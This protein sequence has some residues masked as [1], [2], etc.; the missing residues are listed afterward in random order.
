MSIHNK[1]DATDKQIW[2][3]MWHEKQD[4]KGIPKHFG[5]MSIRTM[6]KPVFKEVSECHIRF[7]K[8]D[9]HTFYRGHTFDI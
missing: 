8:V 9:E 6:I 1:N 4:N 7:T 2:S 5:K 3:Y